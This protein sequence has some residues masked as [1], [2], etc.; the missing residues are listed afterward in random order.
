MFRAVANVVRVKILHR[1][2]HLHFVPIMLLLTQA[3][4]GSVILFPNDDR[5]EINRKISVLNGRTCSPQGL[6]VYTRS[7]GLIR[8]T[9]IQHS[10]FG[11]IN[12]RSDPILSLYHRSTL[13]YRNK[14]RNENNLHYFVLLFVLARCCKTTFSFSEIFIL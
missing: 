9:K 5:C 1:V 6:Y 8:L 4:T 13:P 7:S 3:T 12:Y 10:I 2:F 14:I 11:Y